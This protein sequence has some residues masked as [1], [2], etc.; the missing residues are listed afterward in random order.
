L[1]IRCV[2]HSSGVIISDRILRIEAYVQSATSA[3]MTSRKFRKGDTLFR[4][5]DAG[6]S[7]MLCRKGEIE[8]LREV[9]GSTIRLGYI[10]DGEWL[11]VISVVEYSPRGVTAR[12]VE[13]SE[14]EVLTAREF[15]DWVSNDPLMARNLIRR[16]SVRLRKIVEEIAGEPS[17]FAHDHFE[18]G[19]AE[20]TDHLTIS[21]VPQTETLRFRMDA[22]MVQVDKLP[23][24]V[25]RIPVAREEQPSRPPDLLIEDAE[26]FRLSREHFMIAR[27][28]HQLLV[29]DM[30]SS[31]GTIV[32]GQAIG[33]HFMKDAAPLQRGANHVV[34][35]G[36]DS[37][38][39]FLVS[40]H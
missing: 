24:F 37:P 34:A 2:D 25:G 1:L 18:A 7:A 14:V 23:Y 10:R 12:A 38:F 33:D 13:D 22:A 16:L 26:P 40:V 19:Q 39:A 15:L 31:L 11:G 30:G 9:G 29:S 8:I 3:I 35:G 20:V 21:I 28:G 5:G 27:S 4:Q 6:D 17:S 32:N 36:Q